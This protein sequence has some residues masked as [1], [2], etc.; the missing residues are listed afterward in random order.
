MMMM[1]MTIIIIITIIMQLGALQH[2]N[3]KPSLYKYHNV[4]T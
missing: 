2:Q 3:I 4:I 1:M